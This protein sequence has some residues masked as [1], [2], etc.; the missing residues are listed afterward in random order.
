MDLQAA[1]HCLADGVDR[2]GCLADTLPITIANRRFQ[3]VTDDKDVHH[4]D[5]QRKGLGRLP[6]RR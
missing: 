2:L 3:E 5:P 6:C 4:L 1:M